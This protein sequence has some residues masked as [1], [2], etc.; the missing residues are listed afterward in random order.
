VVQT[1][2]NT[3]YGVTGVG[4]T[5]Q[6]PNIIGDIHSAC[7]S[8]RPQGRLGRSNGLVGTPYI[9]AAAFSVA[10]PYTYGNAPRTLPCQGPGYDNSDI[11]VNKSFPIGERLKVEFRAE[12]LNAFNTP[13]FGTPATTLVLNT[14]ATGAGPAGGIPAYASSTSNQTLGNVTSQLGFPRILQMGGRITF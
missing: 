3:N 11:S 6:R 10:Q 2:L 7:G 1:D 13:Q 9:N 14:G 8:G 12:A 5:S 4:G